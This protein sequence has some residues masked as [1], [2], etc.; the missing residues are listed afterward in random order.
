M[1]NIFVI[2]D[3]HFGHTNMLKFVGVDGVTPV[4]VFSSV[5][6]MNET[7]IDRWNATVRPSD[8]VYHLGDVAIVKRDLILVKRLQGKLRLVAGNHDIYFEEYAK[9]FQKVCGSRVLDNMLLTHFPVHPTSLGR[10]LGNIHGHIHER[11]SPSGPYLNV[12]VE[13]VDY[14]PVSL[15][16][17]KQR[18]IRIKEPA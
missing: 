14:T 10:F 9:Y 7:I 1:A 11:P 8:H 16:D 5:D 17:A 4:R 12:S 18:L 6:E 2:S 15:E 3:T 13:A